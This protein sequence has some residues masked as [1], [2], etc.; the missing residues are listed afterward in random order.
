MMLLDFLGNRRSAAI[1]G[2]A[3]SGKTR[4]L[5]RRI[6]HLPRASGVRP[7]E[8]LAITFT[9][10]AAGEMRSRLVNALALAARCRKPW[11]IIGGIRCAT[12]ANHA[13]AGVVGAWFGKI[14]TGS[15]LDGVVGA[16]MVAMA[17]KPWPW[18]RKPTMVRITSSSSLLG[19]RRRFLGGPTM[20]QPGGRLP[21]RTPELAADNAIPLLSRSLRHLFSAST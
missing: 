6:A 20:F 15:V 17:R 19:T 13:A 3:G 16:S 4:V 5:T 21:G 10:K 14:V 9:N 2:C 11:P 8:I 1:K 7:P 18:R 12:I